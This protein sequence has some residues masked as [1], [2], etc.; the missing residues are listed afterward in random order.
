MAYSGRVVEI[1]IYVFDK[2][3]V[4]YPSTDDV[5]ALTGPLGALKF[6]ADLSGAIYDAYAASELKIIWQFGD[7]TSEQSLSPTHTYNF[8][9]E[10][11]VSCTIYD[12]DGDPHASETPVTLKISNYFGDDV[13]WRTTNITNGI[14]ASALLT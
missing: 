12:K 1:P 7:G 13:V 6:T 3:G 8:P 10:Y 4:Q 2:F 14:L 9:G 5:A 11:E